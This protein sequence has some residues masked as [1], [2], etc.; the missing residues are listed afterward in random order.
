MK[1]IIFIAIIGLSVSV[2]AA[3]TTNATYSILADW[4]AQAR[5]APMPASAALTNEAAGSNTLAL[6]RI[7]NPLTNGVPWTNLAARGFV[8]A[9]L[10]NTNTAT[11]WLTN[12]T[13]GAVQYFG[14]GAA[15]AAQ[16]TNY[17]SITMRIG[18]SEIV[19]ITNTVAGTAIIS[20]E[21]RD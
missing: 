7:V 6:V 13:T 16:S 19:M 20:S 18:P 14:A 3:V 12:I 8:T 11:G 4:I 21:W 5:F 9:N 15:Y 2:N 17:V 1:K 10:C